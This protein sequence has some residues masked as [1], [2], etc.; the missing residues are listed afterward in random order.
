MA[1]ACKASEGQTWSPRPQ[2][3]RLPPLLSLLSSCL[4]IRV[5][6]AARK[7]VH[8]GF[9]DRKRCRTCEA[10]KLTPPVCHRKISSHLSSIYVYIHISRCIYICLYTNTALISTRLAS[11]FGKEGG[12]RRVSVAYQSGGLPQCTVLTPTLRAAAMLSSAVAHWDGCAAST[13]DIAQIAL[14]E[15]PVPAGFP[16]L[17]GLQRM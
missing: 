6:H 8:A 5:S 10:K 16:A 7:I 11:D 2:R 15:R 14:W 12:G 3:S 1:A 17:K 9:H 13:G 4:L